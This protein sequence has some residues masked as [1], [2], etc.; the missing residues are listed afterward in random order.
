MRDDESAEG[1]RAISGPGRVDG[2][3]TQPDGERDPRLLA[4]LEALIRD[5]FP[6]GAFMG[7]E[8]RSWDVEGLK[9]WAPAEPSGNVHGTMF[10]GGIA[11]LGILTGWGW[12]RLELESRGVT[13][14]VVVQD[15]RVTYAR[16][17][18][19][20]CIAW[21]RTPEPDRVERF[22]QTLERKGRGRLGLRIELGPADAGW[23]G[24]RA[25]WPAAVVEARFA[26]VPD[27]TA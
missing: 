22:L 19:G 9:L 13:V 16:P 10:G 12:L 23:T 2:D 7:V 15:A 5:A 25:V 18:E 17:I 20:P 26:C 11:A 4:S 24:D 6:L 1:A 27:P 3:P 21:C 8:P 14:P